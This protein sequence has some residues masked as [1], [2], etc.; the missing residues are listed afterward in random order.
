MQD[1]VTD[2]AIVQLLVD[3]A[4]G[5]RPDTC[6]AV[7]APDLEIVRAARDAAA[8]LQ[9]D[10]RRVVRV[11]LRILSAALHK[12]AADRHLLAAQDRK[13]GGAGAI[14]GISG[15]VVAIAAD[16]QDA[17]AVPLDA[18][19]GE[20]AGGVFFAGGKACAFVAGEPV[21]EKEP[22]PSA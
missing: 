10:L 15:D 20:G 17:L 18:V 7:I 21:V 22:V 2:D 3:N 9:A 19:G 13:T 6:S 1:V 11:R 16:D 8:C 4:V 5:R 12:I 14:E